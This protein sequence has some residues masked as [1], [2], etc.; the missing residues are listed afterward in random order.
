MSSDMIANCNLKDVCGKIEKS[1]CDHKMHFRTILHNFRSAKKNDNVSRCLD[2]WA[3][4]KFQCQSCLV[5]E[6]WNL[7]FYCFE[8]C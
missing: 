4:Y 2:L 3:A 8:G 1:D 5:Q 7:R 6:L